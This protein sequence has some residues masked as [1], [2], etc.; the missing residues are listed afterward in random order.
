LIL[1]LI[2]YISTAKAL[3]KKDG[4]I[5]TH[6]EIFKHHQTIINVRC[7]VQGDHK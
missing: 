1:A 2:Y 5:A 3:H 4:D 7:Q 6:L